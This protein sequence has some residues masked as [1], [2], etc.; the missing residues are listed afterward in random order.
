MTESYGTLN[1]SPRLLLGPGPSQIS[2]RVLRACATPLLGYLDPE[3]VTL[4]DETQQLLREVFETQNDWTFCAPGTGMAGMEAALINMLEPGD[5]V[6]VCVHGV[7]GE[8]MVDVA[9]AHGRA[10][11]ASRCRVGHGR[12]AGAGRSGAAAK[13]AQGGGHRPRGDLDRRTAAAGRDQRAGP[14]GGGALP[15]GLRDL[16]GR[17]AG[18]HGRA[19]D[20]HRLQRH[21]KVHRARR[22]ACRR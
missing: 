11:D 3:Y 13:Q 19:Q 1:P 21:A 16:A 18:A 9:R 22:R 12:Q 15:G 4:M 6:L 17:H 7:F 10:R 5:E 20:R 8:R 2:P 14:R